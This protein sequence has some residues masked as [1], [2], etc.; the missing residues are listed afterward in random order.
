LNNI[1]LHQ[2]KVFE[3][4]ARHC[5]FTRAAEE[6][7][8]T[9]PTVSIQIK[10]LTKGIGLPLFEQV[11][12]RIYLTGAGQELY[13]TCRRMFEEL[14]RLEMGIAELQG[15]KQGRLKI[16][17]VTTAKYF[18]PRLL[19]PFCQTYPGIKVSLQVANHEDLLT[20]LRENLDDLYILSWPPEDQAVVIK[21]FLDNPLVVVAPADHPLAD[22]KQISLER[23]VQEPFIMREWGSGTRDAA[24]KLFD[25]Q[26]LSV[27]VKLALG[28][29]EAIK[30][31]IIGG[32]GL[33][34]LSYHT[35]TSMGTTPQLTVLDVEGFPIARQ[36][37]LVY[38]NRKQLSIVASTFLDY[39]LTEGSRLA[40]ELQL[41]HV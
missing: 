21:P 3:A 35:L 7:Y 33:A 8:L 12:K 4:A 25:S 10:Q 11:G 29:N 37:H 6:L 40:E 16:A 15:M 41:P 20:R 22:Q 34:V 1:T 32:L 5:S 26:G 39:L 9:Q 23:I 28:S 17:A 31:G 36:W 30:Q 13:Q 2:L 18:I 38:S 27:H 19:G 14:S 24:E